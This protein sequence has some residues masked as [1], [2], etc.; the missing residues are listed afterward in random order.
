MCGVELGRRDDFRQLFHVH[1]F[2]IDNIYIV[3]SQDESQDR[4]VL[5]ETLV[6]D[7]EIPQ[8]DPEIISRNVGFLV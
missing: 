2:D 7:I 4:G 6:T 3:I 8:V 5:T 1:R